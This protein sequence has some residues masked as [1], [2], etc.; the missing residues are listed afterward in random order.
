MKHIKLEC[1]NIQIRITQHDDQTESNEPAT[2]T[3]MLN[4]HQISPIRI[5]HKNWT[6]NRETTR[7]GDEAVS[8]SFNETT[9]L[10]YV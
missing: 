2:I 9:T 6:S 10:L 8:S 4:V 1:Q 3:D 5:K 7:V